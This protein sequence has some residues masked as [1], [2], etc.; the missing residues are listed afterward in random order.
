M[1]MKQLRE[2]NKKWFSPENKRFFGDIN[3]KVLQSKKSKNS[4]L[5]Q[6]TYKWSD[7]FDNEKKAV[8]VV[9]PVTDKGAILESV[10]EFKKLSEVKNFLKNK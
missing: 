7:M 5:I 2:K 8:Y 1:N 3:Y 10:A 9:K 4:Y 6:H